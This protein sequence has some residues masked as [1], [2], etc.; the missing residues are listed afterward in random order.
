MAAS[1]KT[2]PKVISLG[3]IRIQ[4]DV[5]RPMVSF[6]IPRA[7]FDFLA[8]KGFL[9]KKNWLEDITESLKSDIFKIP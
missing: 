9:D 8:S 6:V 1:P 4:G 2:P 5:E 7:Q 3:E